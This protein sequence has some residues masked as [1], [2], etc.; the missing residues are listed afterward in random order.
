MKKVRTAPGYKKCFFYEDAGIFREYNH[1]STGAYNMAI[2]ANNR[3]NI[4]GL[5]L[6]C[7]KILSLEVSYLWQRYQLGNILLQP[8]WKE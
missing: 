5:F 1:G 8:P 6:R 2:A 3:G 7:L 4:F